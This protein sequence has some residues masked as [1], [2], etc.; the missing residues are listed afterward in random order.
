MGTPQADSLAV[1]IL[2]D[3]IQGIGQLVAVL[4]YESCNDYIVRSGVVIP[5]DGGYY[6]YSL[7]YETQYAKTSHG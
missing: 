6:I 7:D 4:D 2:G 1:R 5:A 3:D